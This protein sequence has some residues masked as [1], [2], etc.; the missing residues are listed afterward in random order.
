M[1]GSWRR[2][3]RS[4]A[5]AACGMGVI[6]CVTP[7]FVSRPGPSHL[8][9]R[10]GSPAF[11]GKG[12][13]EIETVMVPGGKF[14]MGDSVGAGEFGERPAHLV[15]VSP[16][17]MQRCEVTRGEYVR[18]LNEVGARVYPLFV[19]SFG[20]E[21]RGA[22]GVAYAGR[23]RVPLVELPDGG[24]SYHDGVFEAGERPDL[25]VIVTWFG[26]A[27]YCVWA[28]GRLPTEAEFEY[29]ARAGSEGEVAPSV[30]YGGGDSRGGSCGGELREVGSLAPNAWGLYDMI[31][32][33]PE[34]CV[35]WDAAYNYNLE[36]WR[37]EA[38]R[39]D[40]WASRFG[41]LLSSYDSLVNPYY[42][43][44]KERYPDGV[45]DPFGPDRPG[46]WYDS[47]VIR[48]GVLRRGPDSVQGCWVLRF[49]TTGRY[50]ARSRAQ[51][52]EQAAGFRCVLPN[53]G[54]LY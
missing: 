22:T 18:F 49:W 52:M 4:L 14:L 19:I 43:L 47:K 28:G 32:N 1:I 54:Q 9:G 25:P 20:H 38:R 41:W 5:L 51:P 33:A 3:A 44:C 46:K 45:A 50:S 48:G 6:L 42:Q 13:I 53:K 27:A 40:Y 23:P 29:A 36:Y 21:Y 2:R 12:D 17:R 37:R 31:G 15:W 35:D 26:A 34:W 39:S 30:E 10:L 24:L 16:F 11:A 7:G 8:A